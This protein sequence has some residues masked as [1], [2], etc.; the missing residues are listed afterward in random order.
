MKFGTW[1]HISPDRVQS[2]F[3]SFSALISK[4]PET[5]KRLAVEGNGL[6]F[7]TGR[8]LVLHIW[9]RIDLEVFKVVLERFSALVSV[10]NL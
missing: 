1:E 7:G 3:E 4:W 2:H 9:A 6:P 8:I 5:Q 10:Q